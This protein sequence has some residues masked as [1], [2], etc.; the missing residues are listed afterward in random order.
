MPDWALVGKLFQ[1]SQTFRF[2]NDFQEP[3]KLENRGSYVF[4]KEEQYVDKKKRLQENT[5]CKW[6]DYCKQLGRRSAGTFKM[7][8]EL[9]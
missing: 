9:R 3:I 8:A 7:F 4:W 2:T 5:D 1:F 6:I